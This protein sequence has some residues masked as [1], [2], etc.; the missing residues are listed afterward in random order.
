[1]LGN[2]KVKLFLN[3]YKQN[4]NSLM[5]VFVF[6]VLSFLL[7]SSLYIYIYNEI[8]QIIKNI[9]SAF[10]LTLAFSN[11]SIAQN[12]QVNTVSPLESYVPTQEEIKQFQDY[13]KRK[14]ESDSFL[15]S[16]SLQDSILINQ[17][18]S[19]VFCEENECSLTFELNNNTNQAHKLGVLL[20]V[21][22]IENAVL[23]EVDFLMLDKIEVK[24]G[25]NSLFYKY[26]IPAFV[27]SGLHSFY[28][29]A[30]SESGIEVI[31]FMP[32]GE[33][34]IQNQNKVPTNTNPTCELS[35]TGLDKK[36]N[37]FQGPDINANSEKLFLTCSVDNY[38][39]DGTY[40]KK[41]YTTKRNFGTE[42]G[43][44]ILDTEKVTV[45]DGQFSF[46][47]PLTEKSPQS[48]D[49]IFFLEKNNVRQTPELKAHYVIQGDSA[50]IQFI[51][52]DFTQNKINVKTEITGSAA[53][54]PE[55][56]MYN[57]GGQKIK[58]VYTLLDENKNIKEILKEE[59]SI[60]PESNNNFEVNFK[61]REGVKFFV[62]IK[63]YSENNI[64]L[65]EKEVEI[66]KIDK[67]ITGTET[68][69]Y[70]T[71]KKILA[72]VLLLIL[73]AVIVY[74]IKNKK[75]I[76]TTALFL[77][78]TLLT[79][80]SFAD[81][82]ATYTVG[83]PDIGLSEGYSYTTLTSR[84]FTIG[85]YLTINMSGGVFTSWCGNWDGNVYYYMQSRIIQRLNGKDI[86]SI[87]LDNTGSGK[88]ATAAWRDNKL[89]N[90]YIHDLPRNNIYQIEWTI[91]PRGS[92]PDG[93][94]AW[95]PS[96]DKRTHTY[97]IVNL[98]L[99]PPPQIACWNRRLITPSLG[100]SCPPI[101][102]CGY[103]D[104]NGLESGT[105]RN[106]IEPV[107]FDNCTCATGEIS[108]IRKIFFTFQGQCVIT[109][110]QVT[111][112]SMHNLKNNLMSMLPE[113]AHASLRPQPSCPLREY[114]FC[115]LVRPIV[116]IKF[117]R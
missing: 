9:I 109:G 77:L 54:F 68:L 26:K 55:S 49:Y 79:P 27:D 75:V 20:S 102:H 115:A 56:R 21:N 66:N 93:S 83:D 87:F 12:N 41:A 84:V 64:L 36:F 73:I 39:K 40:S 90:L 67:T 10:C 45:K 107:N 22:K 95:Q 48:Y 101:P 1:L 18:E 104:T 4:K 31:N 15:K 89:A 114:K 91:Y 99:P 74:K 110:S 57:L 35:V 44:F 65:A 42:K 76:E 16:V 88:T 23:R 17:K 72:A 34:D 105:Y 43:K 80:T 96:F 51:K 94:Y 116:D 78:L 59:K 62:N 52:T 30:V 85:N 81:S 50:T 106:P 32:V 37:M 100:E 19:F 25:K 92:S 2:N 113:K 117:I 33:F 14:R 46:E 38:L 86:G 5:R 82:S 28:L 69:K 58:I 29:K 63:T 13:E 97:T 71:W 108:K 103:D 7:I 47:I 111:Y 24:V 70:L 60:S 8:M 98:T 53:N 3:K 112:N 6:K 11:I 61:E